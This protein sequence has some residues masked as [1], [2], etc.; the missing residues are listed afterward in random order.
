MIIFPILHDKQMSNKVGV[1]EYTC[2]LKVDLFFPFKISLVFLWD[3]VVFL[4]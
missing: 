1:V 4:F 2:Q 3:A